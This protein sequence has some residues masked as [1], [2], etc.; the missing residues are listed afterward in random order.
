MRR[1]SCG[2][3]GHRVGFLTAA[4]AVLLLMLFPGPAFA[5]PPANDNRAAPTPIAAFPATV[6]GTTVEATVERLDPQ[7]SQC[8]RVESTVWY[9]IDL[10]PDGTVVLDLSG[11][12]FAPVLRVYNI[13]R[14]AIDELVC[15]SAKTAG[16]ATVGFETTRGSSYLVLVG[17]KPGTADGAFTLKAALFLPPPNDARSQA[18]KMGKLPTTVKGST[19]GAT[20]DDNDPEGC[21]MDT[22]TVWYSLAPGTAE[23]LI[24]TLR[25]GLSRRIDGGPAAGQIRDGGGGLQGDEQERVGSS[26]GAGDEG[27]D[28]P[29][30]RRAE[31]ENPR[32]VI[33][34]CM[35]SAA[36]RERRHPAGSSKFG[37]AGGTLNGLTNVND[38]W[39]V[40]MSSGSTYRISFSSNPCVPMTVR[41]KGKTVGSMSCG[42]YTTFTP[43]PDG[44]GHYLVEVVAPAGTGS[45]SYRL[46]VVRAGTDDIGVGAPIENLATVHGALAPASVD[47]VD[48]Y[49]F[50]VVER[51]DVR[52]RL[53]GNTPFALV[54]LTDSGNRISTGSSQIRRQLER[55]RY[56]VAVRAEIGAPA[57]GYTLGL[58]V[59][60]ITTTT[61]KASTLE[62]APG[63]AVQLAIATAPSPGA[64]TVKVQVDR[65]D[66]LSGWHFYRMMNVSAGVGSIAWTPP[67]L[68]RWRVRA[69]F[70]GTLMFS[71]SRSGYV[72][73]LVAAPLPP[74]ASPL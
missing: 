19:L 26:T 20:Y 30:R 72:S 41:H 2:R 38:L 32:P 61:L 23:R 55:G 71:P 16:T 34:R 22:G 7:V 21:G 50:D 35:C 66:P 62:P 24:V 12:G 53:G 44:G 54:L 70:V 14:S 74:V 65:F 42:G 13:G 3:F 60:H 58:V 73:L 15:S 47:V 18:K 49:H 11:A 51:S 1:Y 37:T 36:R 67:A 5:T 10:A 45:A 69:S 52:L 48:I 27:C 9:R 64:G 68:G 43:G 59:R 6:E 33:S 4:A 40:A 31:G 25:A 39:W 57:A 63:T 46:R 8:G 56:V 28:L 29:G 17:K